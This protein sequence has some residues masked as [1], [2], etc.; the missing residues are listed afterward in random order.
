MILLE[1][2]ED[3]ADDWSLLVPVLIRHGYRE[4]YI[5]RSDT[6]M[7]ARTIPA[8]SELIFPDADH[9]ALWEDPALFNQ[10]V[11]SFLAGG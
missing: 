9:Y 11:L 5:K 7:M 6:D 10:A 2:G 3:A 4:A 1:G 8:A